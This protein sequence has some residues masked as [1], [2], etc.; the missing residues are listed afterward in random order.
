MHFVHDMINTSFPLRRDDETR[1]SPY[2]ETTKHELRLTTRRRN[3]SFA[4]PRDDETRASPYDEMTKHELRLQRVATIGNIIAQSPLLSHVRY[5]LTVVTSTTS[6]LRHR[7]TNARLLA[8]EFTLTESGA[9][10]SAFW[11]CPRGNDPN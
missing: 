8:T 5:S 9:R 3:T 1:A 4:L 11:P 2:D 6:S 10:A 7:C